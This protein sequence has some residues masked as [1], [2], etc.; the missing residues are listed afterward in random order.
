MEYFKTLDRG[1]IKQMLDEKADFVLIDILPPEYYQEVHIKG[2]VNACVYDVNFLQL[3][4]KLSPDKEKPIVV[5]C[6]SEFSKA[7][8]VAQQ[9]LNRAGYPH[10]SIYRGGTLHWQR[11]GHPVEGTKTHNIP[12]QIQNK[13]YAVD[14]AE[15]VIHWI[16]RNIAGARHGTIN[17]LSGSIPIVRGQPEKVSFIIDMD[18]IRNADIQD[19]ALNRILVDHLKSDDFFDTK[20][21]PKARFDA[22]EFKPIEGT[23]K[24]GGVPNYQVTGKLAIKGITH[25]INFPAVLLLKEDGSLAAE[26]HFDID[27][28]L[29][30]INYGSGK[31]FEKLGK[32]LVHDFITIELKLVAKII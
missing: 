7:P 29:W 14:T 18:S 25:E 27:R 19:S 12:V 5:Y 23:E 1:R 21:F 13:V 8:D 9:K 10:V 24:S 16:G 3:V 32:H 20:Q 26:A 30:N 11:A 4:E 31:L 22:T 17:L 6:N 2:A 15:S 28:T